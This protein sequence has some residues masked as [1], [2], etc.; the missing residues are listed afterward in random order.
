MKL[1]LWILLLQLLFDLCLI[2]TPV[3]SFTIPISV[4]TG[5]AIIMALVKVKAVIV[6]VLL[7]LKAMGKVKC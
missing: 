1:A 6:K 2:L 4:Q 3:E 5:M 7:G